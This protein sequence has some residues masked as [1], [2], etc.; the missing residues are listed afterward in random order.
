MENQ[1][2]IELFKKTFSKLKL[3]HHPYKRIKKYLDWCFV[4]VDFKNKTVLDIGGGNGIY[5]Y[6][7][8]SMGAKSALNLEPFASGSTYFEEKKKENLIE[9][10]ILNQTIQEFNSRSKFD[11]IILHDSINHLDEE[12]FSEIHQKKESYNIYVDLVN[13]IISLL[14]IH[15]T[16]IITD[17]SRSNF[18]GDLGIKNPFAPSIEWELHQPPELVLSLFSQLKT[19][20]LIR[21]SP[22]KRFGLIGRF[23]SNFGR[24]P[25]YFLQS[26][27]NLRIS[28]INS[29]KNE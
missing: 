26:H 10:E 22:F 21:W 13:K 24:I 15:G 5:S 18:W 29:E 8:V 6:Y 16:I 3:S 19:N 27:F 2:K 17:C 11:I 7:S 14:N 12:V 4:G 20:S 1:N 9:I 25:S 28:K 23:I